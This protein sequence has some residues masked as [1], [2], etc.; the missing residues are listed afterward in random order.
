MENA[1]R[2]QQNSNSRLQKNAGKT[3]CPA[4]SVHAIDKL[5]WETLAE[6]FHFDDGSAPTLQKIYF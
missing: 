2:A 5:K 4:A 3:Q 6:A 1:S